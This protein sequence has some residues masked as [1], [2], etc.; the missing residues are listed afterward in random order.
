VVIVCPRAL[1]GISMLEY[2]Y[3][4]RIRFNYVLN[5]TRSLSLR[6]ILVGNFLISTINIVI[7]Q[8]CVMFQETEN[9]K[10]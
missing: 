4:G 10:I 3:A 1:I 5:A 8:H 2:V 7:F 6:K 9:V